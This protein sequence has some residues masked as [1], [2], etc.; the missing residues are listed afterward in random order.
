MYGLV[1]IKKRSEKMG[2][3]YL[4]TGIQIGVLKSLINKRNYK[5]INRV[6]DVITE[7]QFIEDSSNTEIKDISIY[8]KNKEK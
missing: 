4:I 7:T 2:G 8:L 1:L 3:R 5:D 6:I